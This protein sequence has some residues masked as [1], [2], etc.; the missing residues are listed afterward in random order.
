MLRSLRANTFS[1]REVILGASYYHQLFQNVLLLLA[2]VGPLKARGSVR[3]PQFALPSIRP[4]YKTSNHTFYTRDPPTTLTLICTSA[5][6]ASAS[7]ERTRGRPARRPVAQHALAPRQQVVVPSRTS[8][9]PRRHPRQTR[10]ANASV[11]TLTCFPSCAR[12]HFSAVCACPLAAAAAY[13]HT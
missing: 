5:D 3:G 1:G 7:A 8:R 11:S 4:Q 9:S 13:P 10:P 12:V 2:T 6:G